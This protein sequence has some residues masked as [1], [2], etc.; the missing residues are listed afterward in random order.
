MGSVFRRVM[1]YCPTCKRR[2]TRDCRE[3]RHPIERSVGK[4][5]HYKIRVGR[6]VVIRST[7]TDNKTDAGRILKSREGKAVDGNFLL[8][9]RI[10]FE[11]AVKKIE[12]DYEQNQR[13]TLGHV[14]RRVEKHL[15]PVFAG[16]LLSEITHDV[17]E[18][19]KA[20]RLKAGASPAE[21]NRELAVLRRGF[22]L[23]KVPWPD[24]AFL[25]EPKRPKKGFFDR[26]QF[27]AVRKALP[28]DLRGLVTFFY[29]TGW[30]KEEVLGLRWRHVDLRSGEIRLD[31]EMVKS[32]E[33]RVFPITKELQSTLKQ[34]QRRAK[35]DFVFHRNGKQITDVRGA[36]KIAVE[37]SK[38]A[39]RTLHD[40]RRTAIRNLERAGVP[41]SAAMAMVGHRTASVYERYAIVDTVMRREAAE[42][43]DRLAAAERLHTG[44]TQVKRRNNLSKSRQ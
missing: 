32:D 33:P 40:F 29:V 25:R 10:R 26:E 28:E 16:L 27:E 39:W 41:R 1:F 38:G 5:W 30:R 17:I 14:R 42:K 31:P 2:P 20:A 34:A 8:P 44:S 4:I 12:T 19:Y 3:G 37:A 21:V 43:L 36:W 13:R 22:N 23:S 15:S 6:K 35:G 24:V 9:P 18:H 7:K 11:D